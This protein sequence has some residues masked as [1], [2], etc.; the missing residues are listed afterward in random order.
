MFILS[1]FNIT[2]RDNKNNVLIKVMNV[3]DINV[4]VIHVNCLSL[5][6]P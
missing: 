4:R 6:Q 3:L 1:I 2:F 5:G